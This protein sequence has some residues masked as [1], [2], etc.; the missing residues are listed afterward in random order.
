MENI[1]LALTF[2]LNISSFINPD[3]LCDVFSGVGKKVFVMNRV[4]NDNFMGGRKRKLVRYHSYLPTRLIGLSFPESENFFWCLIFSSVTKR[5]RRFD[6]FGYIWSFSS[7]W[8]DN[9]PLVG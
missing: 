5:A 1:Y 7:T 2:V 3:Y 4:V 8:G 6:P 9:N